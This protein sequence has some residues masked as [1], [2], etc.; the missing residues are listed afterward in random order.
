[1]TFRGQPKAKGH[2]VNWKTTWLTIYVFHVNFG[3]NIH[4]SGDTAH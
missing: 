1:M 3:H 4:D 2:E